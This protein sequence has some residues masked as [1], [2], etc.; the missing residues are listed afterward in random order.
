MQWEIPTKIAK[1]RWGK[2][3]IKHTVQSSGYKDAKKLSED[4]K[5]LSGNYIHMKKDIETMKKNQ[6][7]MRNT[8]SEMKS[9]LEGI[10]TRLDEADDW[11]SKLA[12]KVEQNTVRTIK[13]KWR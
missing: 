1:W 12:D 10:K 8:I 5:K 4:Y 13:C 3:F 2:Q 6:D 11:I 9:T 7:K